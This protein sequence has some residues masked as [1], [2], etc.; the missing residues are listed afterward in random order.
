MTAL[1]RGQLSISDKPEIPVLG[2]NDV[3]RGLTVVSE[4]GLCAV[5]IAAPVPLAD[6]PGC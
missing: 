1:L 4:P 2:E 3:S 6:F 5:G